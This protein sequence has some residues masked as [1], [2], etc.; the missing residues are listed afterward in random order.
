MPRFRVPNRVVLGEGNPFV[1]DMGIKN[2][3]NAFDKWKTKANPSLIDAIMVALHFLVEITVEA[4]E[5]G[6]PSSQ[7]KK[8][9]KTAV[10][11]MV[12]KELGLK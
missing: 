8:M 12:R 2:L 1:V 7:Q 3:H 9:T 4:C 6:Q 5:K 10:A 11:Q